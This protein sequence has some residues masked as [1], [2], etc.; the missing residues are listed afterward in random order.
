MV[1]YCHRTSNELG[2]VDSFERLMNSEYVC[3][4]ILSFCTKIYRLWI[5]LLCSHL[6]VTFK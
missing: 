4:S 5:Y 1:L 2:K 3:P 6:E